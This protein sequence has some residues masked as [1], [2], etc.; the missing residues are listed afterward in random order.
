MI[1]FKMSLICC[2]CLIILHTC[3]WVSAVFINLWVKCTTR[4]PDHCFYNLV[5]IN[6]M[7]LSENVIKNRIWMQLSADILGRCIIFWIGLQLENTLNE[8]VTRWD[9]FTLFLSPHHVKRST[10]PACQLKLNEYNCKA[11]ATYY[12][13]TT[14]LCHRFWC[15]N[16]KAQTRTHR[17]PNPFLSECGSTPE[18]GI[19]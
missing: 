10:S 18:G 9:C 14:L 11:T 6:C 5:S 12:L 7:S 8:I 16:Y 2:Y 19:L 13:H 3:R 4:S 17:S 15:D 1:I